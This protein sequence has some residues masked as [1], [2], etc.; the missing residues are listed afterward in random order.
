MTRLSV[1]VNKIATLRNARGGNLPDVQLAAR[2][3]QDFGAQGITV[4]PRPDARHITYADVR[5]LRPIVHTE[6]NVEGYPSADFLDLVCT[7]R[8]EQ[9]TLVPDPPDALTSSAGWDT[10]AH[11]AV[12]RPVVARLHDAGIRVSVFLAPD[13]DH[14]AAAADLGV[15]RI[16]LYTGSYAVAHE[17]LGAD[18]ALPFARAAAYAHSMGLGVNA[19]HDLNLQNLRDFASHVPHLAEVSIGHAFV[20]DALYV[21]LSNAVAAYL[22]CLRPPTP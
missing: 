12:L 22:A 17:E 21:G 16:E 6:F 2:R 14:I 5:S 3:L 1:N 8:P 9:V 11:T 7:V 4:H 18:A 13:L 15:D 19:G 20:A 10:V